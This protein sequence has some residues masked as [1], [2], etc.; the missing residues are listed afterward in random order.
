[1]KK[2][3]FS[4]MLFKLS[5]TR[6]LPSIGYGLLVILLSEVTPF[7]WAILFFV[8]L[9]ILTLD[10]M[11]LLDLMNQDFFQTICSNKSI[12]FLCRVMLTIVSLFIFI[13][14]IFIAK[15]VTMIQ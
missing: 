1:M 14:T 12:F 7:P 3:K 10:I 11:L 15:N 5:L 6:I 13:M 2:I 4:L 8:M 9:S